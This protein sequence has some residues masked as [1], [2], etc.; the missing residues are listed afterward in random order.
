M[1]NKETLKTYYET[2]DTPTQEQFAKFIDACVGTLETTDDLPVAT[3]AQENVIY[4]IGKA[5]YQC[6]VLSG[7]YGWQYIGSLGADGKVRYDAGDV[8]GDYLSNR[9]KSGNDI[10][11]TE[12]TGA[13]VNKA[14]IS[15]KEITLEAPTATD[16][17]ITTQSRITVLLQ[18]LLNLWKG[19]YDGKLGY[20]KVT[21]SYSGETLTST[22]TVAEII[23][24]ITAN[25]QIIA[26]YSGIAVFLSENITV[27]TDLVSFTFIDNSGTATI[28][29]DGSGETDSWTLVEEK[30]EKT[31]NKV[32]EWAETPTN[33]TYPGEKLVKDT[34]ANKADLV[35]GLV[36]SSQLPSFVDD[37]IELRTYSDTAPATDLADNDKYYAPTAKLIYTY[38]LD[39]TSWDAGVT[40]ERG[41]IYVVLD[42]SVLNKQYRWG[43]SDMAA[44][45]NSDIAGLIHASETKDIIVNA[46]EFGFVD[47]ENGNVLKKTTW[48]N[49]K[50]KLQ[51]FLQSAALTITEVWTFTSLKL[52]IKGSSTGKNIIASANTGA[53]DC[54]HTLQAKSGVIAHKTDIPTNVSNI[55][56]FDSI[57]LN[58]LPSSGI[59]QTAY[60]NGYVVGIKNNSSSAFYSDV[61]R[62]NGALNS[63]SLPSSQLWCHVF[64]G[65]NIFVA[66][67][68]GVNAA[69]SINNGATWSALTLPAGT[70]NNGCYGELNGVG[71]YVIVG[72]NGTLIYSSDLTNWE[73][74][75]LPTASTYTVPKIIFL[76][77]RFIILYKQDS[78]AY[79]LNLT[80]YTDVSLPTSY[81]YISQYNYRGS[82][83]FDYNG[84]GIILLKQS[85]NL[86]GISI[87]KGVSFSSRTM[88][89]NRNWTGIIGGGS[90]IIFLSNNDYPNIS[91]DG[92]TTFTSEITGISYYLTGCYGNNKYFLLTTETFAIMSERA[93]V[94]ENGNI[95]RIS[96]D[97][98][99][100][101]NK[102]SGLK[103]NNVNEN[104]VELAAKKDSDEKVK[105]DASD[106]TAGYIVDKFV[107][108]T[109]ISLAEGTGANENKLVIASTDAG[110]GDMLAATY[111]P[112]NVAGDA[113]DMDNMVEGTDT[114]I[115]TAAERTKIS[116][117]LTY[118]TLTYY[119]AKPATCS[120]GEK[121][122]D[123]SDGKIYT[124]TATDTWDSGVTASTS[125]LYIWDFR[126]YKYISGTTLKPLS[127]GKKLEKSPTVTSNA[128]SWECKGERSKSYVSNNANTTCTVTPATGDTATEHS[129]LFTNSDASASHTISFAAASG[130]TLKMLATTLTIPI[131][132]CVE[133][134]VE[135]YGTVCHIKY[136][137][138]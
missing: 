102:R 28:T 106:P 134:S 89:K 95:V 30:F 24:A 13:D 127:Y 123:T 68:G 84:V 85:S 93:L 9:M 48:S 119:Q 50:L 1:D 113:F 66:L 2:G 108:G 124:A 131:G 11:V 51:A 136:S 122:F 110:S 129:L 125:Y 43:G 49:I 57:A 69:K 3:S 25:K 82:S 38:D 111:D 120:T 83:D 99:V 92:G 53:T 62:T 116:N 18:N 39:T 77:D 133:L 130:F 132:G 29:G 21:F 78:I 8:D 135:L 101:D 81:D 59:W 7:I 105:Y 65:G 100:T 87:N 17:P 14:V 90:S 45:V 117:S 98:I 47:S 31:S 128:F 55:K 76:E 34:F 112:T 41:K 58:S 64:F 88:Q 104:I 72:E 10:D 46:D 56:F 37:V 121:C 118:F 27:G 26:Y 114:K 79:T 22:K 138:N 20:L 96:G 15:L 6:K 80:S 86:C 109:G 115:L 23:A 126:I 33:T 94:D 61:L 91:F 35:D 36:P 60:G 63:V 16:T 32:S 67:S 40:P 42:D 44:I 97:F 4:Q 107:A 52:A 74:G 12:G 5:F 71:Y 103:T 54:T 70:W 19:L 75:T 137:I 73:T